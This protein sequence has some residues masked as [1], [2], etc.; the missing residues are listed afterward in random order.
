MDQSARR[1]D[2]VRRMAGAGFVAA[3]DEVD[4]LV[5]AATRTGLDLDGLVARR[6][7]G[8]PL[9]WVTGRTA[10]G[11]LVV[12]VDSGVY[13]P[14]PRTVGLARRAVTRLPPGGV[15]IDVCTGAGAIAATLSHTRPTARVVGTDVDVASVA[16]ARSNGV[17]AH[18]GDLFDPVPDGLSGRVDL[19]VGS[20]PYVPTPALSSLQRDTFTFEATTAYDGGGDGL[21]VVRRVLRDARSFLRRGGWILLELGGGQPDELADELVQLGYRDV[22]TPRDSDGDVAGVEA[23]W[24]GGSAVGR[25]RPDGP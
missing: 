20:V 9:A 10:F 2:L 6:L 15:A 22:T 7:T 25:G 16:C 17:E 1:S 5:A 13:V 12:R 11:D 23:S 14:R 4:H 8:E 24:R 21:D 19:V 3:G 18:L